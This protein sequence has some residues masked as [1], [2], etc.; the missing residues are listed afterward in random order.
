METSLTFTLSKRTAFTAFRIMRCLTW[1]H[2]CPSHWALIPLD[3][4]LPVNKWA[5]SG[6][7]NNVPWENKQFLAARETKCKCF[8]WWNGDI[9]N[10]FQRCSCKTVT[11]LLRFAAVF[12]HVEKCLWHSSGLST[13]ESVLSLELSNPSF[14]FKCEFPNLNTEGRKKTQKTSS[15]NNSTNQQTT[16]P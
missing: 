2:F 1:S 16:T 13:P 9:F 12:N 7:Y 3:S 14:R 8:Q 6:K 4:L 11:G 10:V 5:C 15:D